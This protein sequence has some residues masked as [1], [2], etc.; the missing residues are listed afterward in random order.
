MTNTNQTFQ[1]NLLTILK[2]STYFT[3]REIEALTTIQENLIGN[4]SFSLKKVAELE[5]NDF[6]RQFLADC[7]KKYA[8]VQTEVAHLAFIK[9]V[10]SIPNRGK[11]LLVLDD[12]LAI[13]SGKKISCAYRWYDHS[14]G[15]TVT[16][17]CIVNV[18][19]VV[20]DQLLFTIPWILRKR[21][22]ASKKGCSRQIEQDEKTRVAIEMVDTFVQ[23][24]KEA[25]I[26]IERLVVEA[27][28][29]YG[30]QTMQKN[31][32][33]KHLFY[34][35]DGKKNYLVQEP[36]PEA[37]KSRGKKRRGRK[38]KKYVKYRR[39]DQ[40]LG[41]PL[42]W[43]YFRDK[44]TGERVHH[45]KRTLTLKSAGRVT[46]YAFKRET[47]AHPKF[48]MT[49]IRKWHPPTKETVYYQYKL[50]WRI[51]ES[52][53]D[54][55]Q[56]FGLTKCRSRDAWVIHGFT[57]LVYLSYSL[58]KFISFKSYQTTG[59]SLKSPSWSESFFFAHIHQELLAVVWLEVLE[60]FLVEVI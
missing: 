28:A 6:G 45:K 23:W 27:D 47:L 4:P 38:R 11:I 44:T 30:N 59:T 8:Y 33:G 55:K 35:I 41:N 14:T 56:Q 50:R 32:K 25:G 29:W 24:F 20:N 13:K 18:A 1:E 43:P 16:A 51:E 57:G 31:L 26:S 37:L 10:P 2:K 36:D 7:L 15:K 46:I 54:L 3:E 52:H 17:F 19:I 60:M 22:K 5:S 34:E 9:M 58:W 53:R 42:E 48:L 12:S 39:L 21:S 49:P 40:Y